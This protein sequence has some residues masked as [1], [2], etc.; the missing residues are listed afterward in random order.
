MICPNCRF[1]YTINMDIHLCKCPVC[2][3][4]F[5]DS[6]IM[7]SNDSN[8]LNLL[9]DG[10]RFIGSDSLN[11]VSLL[12][13]LVEKLYYA[14]KILKKLLLISIKENISVKMYKLITH[15]EKPKNID[16][17]KEQLISEAF[18]S[19]EFAQKMIDCWSYVLDFDEHENSIKKV[20]INNYVNSKGEIIFQNKNRNFNLKFSEGLAYTGGENNGYRY[21]DV[22]GK[23]VLELQPLLKK[24][25]FRNGDSET[26]FDYFSFS[27]FNE[28]LALVSYK[29]VGCG[30]INKNAKLVVDFNYKEA[31]PFSE[32]LAAVRRNKTWGYIDSKGKLKIKDKYDKVYSF[33]EG[34][35]LVNGND[36]WTFIDPNDIIIISLKSYT[37]AESFR[38]GIARVKKDNM[39]GFIDKFGHEVI[40]L[41]YEDTQT[42]QNDIIPVKY[43]KWGAISISEDVVI[44]LK[45]DKL[46][47][48]CEGIMLVGIKTLE[49]P[50][51]C[52]FGLYDTNGNQLL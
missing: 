24:L 10:I 46:S 12:T 34:L 4:K 32:G 42:I 33:S 16:M 31:L 37:E 3:E 50:Y 40:P 2:K 44:P 35:A 43:K 8:A 30:F 20:D 7:L 47:F 11:N 27:E 39:Y 6:L 41:K 25:L 15:S 45:F 9:R 23:T 17:L 38:Y 18:L 36:N 13:K 1:D 29:W 28:G 5:I 21:I 51:E 48:I 49:F 26:A 19:N 22:N 52:L 14:D